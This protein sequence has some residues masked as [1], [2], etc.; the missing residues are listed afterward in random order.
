MAL[1]PSSQ[2]VISK[3]LVVRSALRF[4]WL[5]HVVSLHQSQILLFTVFRSEMS[6][7]WVERDQCTSSNAI[8]VWKCTLQWNGRQHNTS[9][10][11]MNRKAY[12]TCATVGIALGQVCRPKWCPCPRNESRLPVVPY[13]CY[14]ASKPMVDSLLTYSNNFLKHIQYTPKIQQQTKNKATAKASNVRTPDV[15]ARCQL[16]NYCGG[17]FPRWSNYGPLP[18]NSFFSAYLSTM[19]WS[20]ETA[21]FLR[22]AA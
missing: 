9:L 14:V 20:F 8:Q 3:V 2:S 6:E 11:L 19:A 10:V 16:Q 4:L 7:T 5:V 22:A 18:G 17:L 1:N 12:H 21:R 13:W 15:T